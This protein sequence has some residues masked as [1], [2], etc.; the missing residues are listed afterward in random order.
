MNRD[1]A[2]GEINIMQQYIHVVFHIN[3]PSHRRERQ[4]IR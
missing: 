2:K 3:S 1:K 4:Q